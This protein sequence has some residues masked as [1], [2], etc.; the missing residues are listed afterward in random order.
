MLFNATRFKVVS[1]VLSAFVVLDLADSPCVGP[2]L[3]CYNS[4]FMLRSLA[5]ANLH[6]TEID[7]SPL[8]HNILATV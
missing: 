2:A 5:F 4:G 3:G 6:S 1:N 7:L 8:L